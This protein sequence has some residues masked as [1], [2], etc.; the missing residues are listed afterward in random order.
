LAFFPPGALCAKL[1]PIKA[2]MK[3]LVATSFFIRGRLEIKP[4]SRAFSKTV[5]SGL[6]AILAINLD[7]Q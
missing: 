6:G 2:I 5:Y 3:Q 1:G 7:E 4:G